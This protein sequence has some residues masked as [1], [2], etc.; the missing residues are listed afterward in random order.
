MKLDAA[1]IDRVGDFPY[2]L[3]ARTLPSSLRPESVSLH[4]VSADRTQFDLISI[5]VLARR[6]R[7][8][9]TINP[10]RA[11]YQLWHF[12]ATGPASWAPRW[13]SNLAAHRAR[14]HYP[15]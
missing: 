4:Y 2:A 5:A 8:D 7:K 14:L 12:A 15:V 3:S 1:S 6:V 9:G 10:R 13:L 11:P